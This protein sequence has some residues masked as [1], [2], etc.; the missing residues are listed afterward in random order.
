MARPNP[1]VEQGDIGSALVGAELR[2]IGKIAA[3]VAFDLEQ[4]FS[5]PAGTSTF[6]QVTLDGSVELPGFR[7]QTL[8]MHAHGVGTSSDAAPR[9]RYAYLGGSGTL[10]TLDLLEMG[11]TALVYLESRYLIPIEKIQLP[12]NLGAPSLTLRDAFGSAG[13]G[14]LPDFQHE[15]GI[16]IGLGLDIL[17]LEYTRAVAGKRGSEFGVGISLPRI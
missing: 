10:R 14:S 11:G 1:L 5:V 12:F 15:V 13:V 3:R 7:S 6:T 17:R 8:T 2:T 4:G 9:A 16:G